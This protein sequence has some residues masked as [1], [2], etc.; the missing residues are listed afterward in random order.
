MKK[1]LIFIIT[2]LPLFAIGQ[3][4]IKPEID[5]R[6][7]EVFE[8]DFLERMQTL[9]PHYIEYQNFYLDNSYQII[10]FPKGKISEYPIIE[11]KDLENLNIIRLR[12]EKMFKKQQKQIKEIEDLINRFRSKSSKIGLVKDRMKKLDK[13]N[14]VSKY[15]QNVKNINMDIKASKSSGEVLRI[16]DWYFGYDDEIIVEDVNLSIFSGDKIAF[17]GPNGIGER[18]TFL[19]V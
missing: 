3:S 6:L 11:V 15:K 2:I 5:E 7:Y 18:S 14:V 10:D 16:S 1:V 12:N 19:R 9:K 4:D 17:V 13:M 8:T